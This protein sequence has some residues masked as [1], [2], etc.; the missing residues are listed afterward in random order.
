[1]LEKELDGK[2]LNEFAL[3]QERTQK[4][5][6]AIGIADQPQDEKI[7]FAP[8]AIRIGKKLLAEQELAELDKVFQDS[9]KEY[10]R[11]ANFK[12]MQT[13]NR[14]TLEVKKRF[15]KVRDTLFTQGLAFQ[16]KVAQEKLDAKAEA[17]MWA[18]FGDVAASLG[19]AFVLYNTK[20]PSFD[21]ASL[22][23]DMKTSGDARF[24]STAGNFQGGPGARYDTMEDF[25]AA[26]VDPPKV[27]TLDPDD[28]LQSLGFV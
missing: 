11:T 21:P 2:L 8:K 7:G 3:A 28:F 26:Q 4:G 19:K 23:G 9:M 22:S 15:A 16:K 12:D 25:Q 18:Q 1:M 27:S 10:N 24:E 14:E 13:R 17:F 20:K 6:L 5:K